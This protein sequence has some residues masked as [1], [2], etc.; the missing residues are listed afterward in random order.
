MNTKWTISAVQKQIVVN[1][2]HRHH[3][4]HFICSVKTSNNKS[5]QQKS[6]HEQDV[7][8]SFEHL[9]QPIHLLKHFCCQGYYLA[10]GQTDDVAV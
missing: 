9:L 10:D 6:L 2:V 3:H 8:G 4:H 5:L 1:S 7:S